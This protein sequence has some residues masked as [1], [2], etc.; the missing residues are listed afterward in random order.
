[1]FP[2]W[3]S[4]DFSDGLSLPFWCCSVIRSANDPSILFLSTLSSRECH[5]SGVHPG[6]VYVSL[7][8]ATIVHFSF[9][10][11]S[12]KRKRSLR[13]GY[14]FKN[15]LAPFKEEIENDNLKNP[16]K[17]RS[18]LIVVEVKYSRPTAFTFKF[19]CKQESADNVINYQLTALVFAHTWTRYA[20]LATGNGCKH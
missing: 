16:T 13:Y 15:H 18:L 19:H 2:R 8:V 5:G 14:L 6:R 12:I 11:R 1:M 17:S 10:W 3:S 20:L 7:F 9:H 4:V